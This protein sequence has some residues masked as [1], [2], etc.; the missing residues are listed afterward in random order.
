MSNQQQKNRSVIELEAEVAS[1]QQ[2]LLQANQQNAELISQMAEQGAS[3]VTLA[4]S[5][6]LYRQSDHPERP[7][8]VQLT[9]RDLLKSKLFQLKVLGM[10]PGMQIGG[11]FQALQAQVADQMNA[12]DE[13]RLT[14][15]ESIRDE[16]IAE[17]LGS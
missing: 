2:A 12:A 4:V 13:A 17:V 9:K 8:T 5:N 10:Q 11:D 7:D 1:L 14:E 15:Q 6:D 16:A 3:L